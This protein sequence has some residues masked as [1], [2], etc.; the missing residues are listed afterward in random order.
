M[1]KYIKANKIDE[2]RDSLYQTFVCTRTR[3]DVVGFFKIL[4]SWGFPKITL[5]MNWYNKMPISTIKKMV[6]IEVSKTLWGHGDKNI[7]FAHWTMDEDEFGIEHEREVIQELEDIFY[8]LHKVATKPTT[9]SL[10]IYQ[11]ILQTPWKIKYCKTIN[12]QTTQV[13][14]HIKLKIKKK[15]IFSLLRK[16]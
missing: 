3:F 7:N 14:N 16:Y 1:S 2:M 8:V 12:T 4:D 15:N 5:E 10:L 9:T 6:S 11:C 13:N